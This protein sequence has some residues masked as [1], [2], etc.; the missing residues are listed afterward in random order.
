MNRVVV[1][2]TVLSMAWLGLSRPVA[3]ETFLKEVEAAAQAWQFS[4]VDLPEG[5]EA[6]I[7]AKGMWTSSPNFGP[8]GPGGGEVTKNPHMVKNGARHG[9]LLVRTGDTVRDFSRDDQT[10]KINTAGPIYFCS[11]DA[12]SKEGFSG[13]KDYIHGIPIRPVSE[14]G[15]GFADNTGVLQVRIVVRKV[16]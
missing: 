10:I 3:G 6:I 14:K 13:A 15:V 16:D 2:F 9:A 4:G 5:Y 12:R 1:T 8:V 11:N 7:T